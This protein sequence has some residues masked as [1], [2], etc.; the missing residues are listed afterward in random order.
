M[1]FKYTLVT[2]AL[3][4]I[5]VA[6]C[7]GSESPPSSLQ[8][9][10]P[11]V[12]SV[13][14]DGVEVQSKTYNTY[15]VVDEVGT[16]SDKSLSE[17]E[18][19]KLPHLWI[20]AAT[21]SSNVSTTPQMSV[22]QYK[23][24]YSDFWKSIRHQLP[25]RTAAQIVQ[26]LR[27]FGM[28]IDELCDRQAASGLTVDDYVELFRVVEKYW[29]DNQDINGKIARFFTDLKITPSAFK[30]TL[31]RLGYTW[32]DF[33]QKMA[34]TDSGGHKFIN[35]FRLSKLGFDPFL[36][37]YMSKV[38][39][40]AQSFQLV[41][42]R[43]N[44]ADPT[45]DIVAALNDAIDVAAN[46]I[47]ISKTAWQFMRDNQGVIEA[48]KGDASA[49]IIAATD[50]NELNYQ[51]AKSSKSPTISFV[52]K[53]FL[54]GAWE[55]Y[56][57]DLQLSVDYGA[58]H[59]DFGGQWIPDLRVLVKKADAPWGY[60]MAGDV[61]LSAVVN[62]GSATDPIPEVQ[63]DVVMSVSYLSTV[64]QTLTFSANGATGAAFVP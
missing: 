63:V 24:C 6:G 52:G 45:T 15:S 34:S 31:N 8:A 58:T 55:T 11:F 51:F 10:Q 38:T 14:V 33:V 13:L 3:L 35:E 37:A 21:S 28:T 29:P 25:E 39:P 27:D 5:S 18:E 60:K 40:A 43:I 46:I 16:L 9:G 61:V 50:A 17:L 32:D 56:R 54:F 30:A 47:S 59:P 12:A 42:Q 19:S 57:T 48:I 26:H 20:L 22:A 44:A 7:G 53:S 49:K 2:S 23:A 64:N 36:D 62:R 41:R 1:S 4:S